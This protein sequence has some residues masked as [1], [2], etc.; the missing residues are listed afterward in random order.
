MKGR[1]ELLI[2]RGTKMVQSK[3]H[4]LQT[5]LHNMRYMTCAER[6]THLTCSADERLCVVKALKGT[7]LGVKITSGDEEV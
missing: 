5:I 4:F 6:N 2:G 7:D 1:G 3:S